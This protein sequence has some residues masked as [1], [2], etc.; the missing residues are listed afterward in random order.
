M[1][2]AAR[3]DATASTRGFMELDQLYKGFLPGKAT[4]TRYSGSA[5]YFAYKL[6]EVEDDEESDEKEKKE[7]E[8]CTKEV[9]RKENEGGKAKADKLEWD[10]DCLRAEYDG[11]EEESRRTEKWVASH[12]QRPETVSANVG[13]KGTSSHLS[14]KG[15]LKHVDPSN[16]PTEGTW[17]EERSSQNYSSNLLN[18]KDEIP[19]NYFDS[20]RPKKV[21]FGKAG[22]DS[23]EEPQAF[24]TG[25]RP[26]E[27][28]SKQTYGQPKQRTTAQHAS[29]RHIPATS[30]SRPMPELTTT[31]L[32]TEP[33]RPAQKKLPRSETTRC[34]SPRP[35]FQ[36]PIKTG[37]GRTIEEILSELNG[38]ASSGPP[39][40]PKGCVG[41]REGGEPWYRRNHGRRP[42]HVY[43][44]YKLGEVEDDEESD[45]KEKKEGEEC[46]KEVK[47]KENEGG[48]AKADKLEW[49][50]DCLRAEYDGGEEESRRTDEEPQVFRTGT[51]A[52]NFPAEIESEE[53]DEGKEDEE[54]ADRHLHRPR[55]RSA[56]LP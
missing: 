1:A 41:G 53:K 47:R 23:D 18:S 38:T 31:N 15:C 36:R 10:S 19:G 27:F 43:F 13:G 42:P 28:L 29:V 11:G 5:V 35:L 56:R 33:P 34:P 16:I 26:K 40:P 54:F 14:L 39:R 44:A 48:K 52:I 2:S 45:E 7:G 6:G 55:R 25:I 8:E 20:H 21:H 37:P 32:S 4:E 24:R 50:S 30:L 22:T 17:T 46:T 12:S 9:K 3:S 49:D 51:R